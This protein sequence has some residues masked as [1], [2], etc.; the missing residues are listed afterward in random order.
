MLSLGPLPLDTILVLLALVG[1]LGVERGLRTPAQPSR[2]ARLLDAFLVG[3]ATAR[4]AFVLRGW[5]AYAEEPASLLLLHDGGYNVPAGIAGAIVFVL[6]RTAGEPAARRPLVLSIGAGVAIWLALAATL[7]HQRRAQLAVPV[8]E[9]RTIDGA[10]VTLAAYAG[11]PLV[12]NLWATWCPPCRREMPALAQAQARHP[13]IAFVFVNQGEE[14]EAVRRY[15]AASGLSLD[16]LLLDAGAS[17]GAAIGSNSLPTTLFFDARGRF[18]D[19][20]V[21]ALSRAGLQAKLDAL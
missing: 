16:H 14:A 1:A 13:D 15:L 2:R 8:L 5:P 7:A 10:P 18:V 12:L 20:Q 19:A 9:L 11:R 3:W 17:A 21:G 6:W 4:L